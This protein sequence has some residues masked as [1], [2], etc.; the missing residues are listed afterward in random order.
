MVVLFLVFLRS[1]H[2]VFHSSCTN[3]HSHQQ[4][5][6]VPF[7]PHPAQHLLCVFFLMIAILTGVRWCLIVVLI[8]V[9]L[10]ISN[11][12]HLFMCLLAIC[13]SSFE[14]SLFSS[15]AH[16][17]IGFFFCFLMWSCTS[18]LYMLDINPLSLI[19]FANIFSHSAGCLF[20][21][22]MV[23]IAVQKLLSL[24]RSHLFIFAFISF[25]LG[26]PVNY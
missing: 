18:H 24:I 17:L 20:V 10:M 1:L 3:L 14:K 12:E 19:S 11:V 7:S 9:S 13:I 22:P 15:Y 21:L 6:K 5:T 16:L 4:C 2:I 8:C 26:C 23:S 25:A